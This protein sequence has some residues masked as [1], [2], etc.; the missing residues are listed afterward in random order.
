MESELELELELDQAL[1]IA[2][3]CYLTYVD[4]YSKG[5]YEQMPDYSLQKLLDANRI[6]DIHNK[7]CLTDAL[8]KAIRLSQQCKENYIQFMSTGK[9]E[10]LTTPIAELINADDLARNRGYETLGREKLMA[11]YIYQLIQDHQQTEKIEENVVI[12][13]IQSTYGKPI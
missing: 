4:F 1:E 9:F 8:E 3:Q 13:F 7:A 6:A 5:R 10:P 2:A 12:S 11:Y